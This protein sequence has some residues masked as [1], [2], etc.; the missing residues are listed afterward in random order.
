MAEADRDTIARVRAAICAEITRQMGG[1]DWSLPI[2]LDP[3]ARVAAEA[4][5]PVNDPEGLF[6]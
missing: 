1:A 4:A 2:A 3:V 5:A 6:A